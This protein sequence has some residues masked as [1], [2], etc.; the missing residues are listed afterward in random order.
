MA[1]DRLSATTYGALKKLIEDTLV[2]AGAIK[3]APCEV[4]SI[5]DIEGGK[6]V[7]FAW[8]DSEGETHTANMDVMNGVNGIDGKDGKDGT[9]GKDG[10]DGS[11]ATPSKVVSEATSY[12]TP[13][14]VDTYYKFGELTSFALSCDTVWSTDNTHLH[15]YMFE[16]ESGETPT[17]FT[18]DSTNLTLWDSSF[19]VK[20]STKYQGSVVEGVIVI[21]EVG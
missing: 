13:L 20:A 8:E 16:F 21:C 1:K 19:T 3:G 17:T 10:R 5:T 9:D 18:Y 2:S 4:Q 15:E 12:S 7:T 11:D 14:V 6:R